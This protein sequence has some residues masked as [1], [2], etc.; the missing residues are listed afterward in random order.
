MMRRMFVALTALAV[1][2]AL[3]SP[4]SAKQETVTGKIIDQACY[5]RDN[6][7]TG[8]DHKMPRGDTKDCAIACAKMGR[9]LAILTSDGKVYQLT[10][11]LAASNNEKLV[12]HVSHT[13]EGTGDA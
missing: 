10:G 8:V 12:P 13:A 1:I 11:G 5:K 7:N 9:P 4:A 6:S 3:G 2:V